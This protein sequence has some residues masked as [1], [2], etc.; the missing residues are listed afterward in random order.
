MRLTESWVWDCPV[1]CEGE[2][3][4]FG[5]FSHIPVGLAELFPPLRGAVGHSPG[6]LQQL[7]ALRDSRNLW[8]LQSSRSQSVRAAPCWGQG[9]PLGSG[10]L[11][12]PLPNREP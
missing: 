10:R 3:A 5:S 8:M 4:S 2:E 7:P 11:L 1:G 12:S 9:L 6:M